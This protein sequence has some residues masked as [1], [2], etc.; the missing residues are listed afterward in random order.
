MD[1]IHTGMRADEAPAQGWRTCNPQGVF[2]APKATSKGHPVKKT[3]FGKKSYFM[4]NKTCS[5]E[6]QL[7]T[8]AIC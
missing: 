6:N 7:S 2:A 3:H 5:A 4:L 1:D 8:I